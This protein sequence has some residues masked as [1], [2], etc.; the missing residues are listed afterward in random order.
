MGGSE[1]TTGQH[2]TQQARKVAHA[3]L[4]HHNSITADE[5]ERAVGT[6]A[7]ADELEREVTR[8]TRRLQPKGTPIP[9]P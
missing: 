7:S 9:T 5:L 3:E 4:V 6:L 2:K 1:V 8:P